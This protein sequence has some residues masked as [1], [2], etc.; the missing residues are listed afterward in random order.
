MSGRLARPV[1]A[2]DVTDRA[3]AAVA[4]DA[5]R[6]VAVLVLR[7]AAPDEAGWLVEGTADWLA[8]R[9]LG[10]VPDPAVFPSPFLAAKGTL[11]SPGAAAVIV[12]ELARR[13]P[14]PDDALRAAWIEAGAARGDDSESFLRGLA[15]RAA[16]GGL[17][18]LMADLLV[19]AL[20]AAAASPGGE[21]PSTVAFAPG[22]FELPAPPPLGWQRLSFD[23]IDERAGLEIALP[24][25]GPFG[26]GRA[27]VVYRGPGGEHD[28]VPLRRGGSQLV[29]LSGTRGLSLVVVDGDA[30]SGV[31][32]RLRRVPDY[33]LKLASSSASFADGAV[34]LTWRTVAHRD[35]LAW[36]V[37]RFVEDED[38]EL[39]LDGREL[40][41]TTDAQ[42]GGFGYRLLDRDARPGTSYRYR[43]AGLTRDGFLSE[44]FEAAVTGR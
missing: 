37:T 34:E 23:G 26:A 8:R 20:G 24:E 15:A 10:L 35:L 41:P 40:V 33:P 2:V 30:R 5:V 42:P 27:L 16:P 1:V 12:A 36:V 29:P 44:A 21:V 38:G 22:D 18:E 19:K 3:P 32:V 7:Q 17:P 4:F 28:A 11:A 6:Q 9:L 43:V 39:R 25:S 31:F 14:S 13:L